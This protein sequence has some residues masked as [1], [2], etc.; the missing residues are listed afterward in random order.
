MPLTSHSDIMG[1]FHESAFNNVLNEI[2]L[3]R[4]S[5]FNYATQNVIDNN[6]FCTPIAMNP[7]LELMDI[8][9]CTKVDKLPI[10]GSDDPDLGIDF[11]A[12]LKELKIDFSPGSE[13]QLPPELG[14]L[15]YQQFSLKGTVCAGLGCNQKGFNK[16]KFDDIFRTN[17]KVKSKIS[18]EDKGIRFLPVEFLQMNCFCLSLYAKVVITRD[19]NYLKMNLVGIELVDISPLGLENSIECYLKQVLDNV[20]FPKIKIA[21]ADLVF[22]VKDYFT[23][24]LTPTSSSLPYNPDV[25]NNYLSIFLNIN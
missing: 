5:T 14:N 13:I 17:K 20:V 1:R 9:K 6:R 19:S 12:Q 7:D 18:I 25:S 2:M 8:E 4:P 11:C 23:I 16:W 10:I 21:F 22:N 24:S 3:Q 15:N